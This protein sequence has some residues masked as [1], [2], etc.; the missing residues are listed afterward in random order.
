M[1]Q[2]QLLDYGIYPTV[3]WLWN[4]LLPRAITLLYVHVKTSSSLLH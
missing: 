3:I 2:E 1:E 4:Q